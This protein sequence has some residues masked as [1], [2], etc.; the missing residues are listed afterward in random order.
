MRT[1]VDLSKAN[2]CADCGG[3]FPAVAMDYDH[4]A[5]TTKQYNVSELC[6]FLSTAWRKIFGE[7][8][9]CDLVC[10]NCH[11]VRTSDRKKAA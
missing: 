6:Q 1:L 8:A 5:G 11:R 3:R 2:P 9:K 7:I 10:S 4:R